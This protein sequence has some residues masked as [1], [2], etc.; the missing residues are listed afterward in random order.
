MTVSAEQGVDAEARER[1]H[2]LLKERFATATLAFLDRR[3]GA[4]VVRWG[5]VALPL[6]PGVAPWLGV[7]AWMPLA[8]MVVFQVL[9]AESGRILRRFGALDPR[10]LWRGALNGWVWCASG[11]SMVAVS[12]SVRSIFWVYPLIYLAVVQANTWRARVYQGIFAGTGE[13]GGGSM[14]RPL[15]FGG[16]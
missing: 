11:T 4:A 12:G 13:G 15:L 10:Y 9:V 5:F 14:R 6:V 1:V 7:P 3:T 16:R 2:A 8:W